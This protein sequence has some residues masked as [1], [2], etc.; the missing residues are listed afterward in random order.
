MPDDTVMQVTKR[1]T[2]PL[3]LENISGVCPGFVRAKQMLK[4]GRDVI[5]SD[6]ILVEE[7]AYPSLEKM[8][9]E[10]KSLGLK[11]G[12][13]SS[14]EHMSA[15]PPKYAYTDNKELLTWYITPVPPVT[16][17]MLLAQIKDRFPPHYTW[18]RMAFVRDALTAVR[19][20]FRLS[21]KVRRNPLA[22]VRDAF[23]TTRRAWPQRLPS[24]ERLA[25]A[26]LLADIMRKKHNAGIFH[27]NI[28]P[29]TVFFSQAVTPRF[30]NNYSGVEPTVMAQYIPP[31]IRHRDAAL[32]LGAQS[33]DTYSVA[34]AAYELVTGEPLNGPAFDLDPPV[35]FNHPVPDFLT[36]RFSGVL[37]FINPCLG[38][39]RALWD[40][41]F[42]HYDEF[43]A[44]FNE[45]NWPR[46]RR[47][48]E[49]TGSFARSIPFVRK[50]LNIWFPTR[51]AWALRIVLDYRANESIFGATGRL[52][53][54]SHVKKNADCAFLSRAF[55]KRPFSQKSRLARLIQEII[56]ENTVREP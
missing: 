50:F 7:V 48:N 21:F 51:T 53:K 4:I 44:T 25:L 34:L 8:T 19:E 36:K 37:S 27:N 42:R 40:A 46:F 41:V 47:L 9:A 13:A 29:H 2:E 23:D 49:A 6:E 32:S 10:L 35:A 3:S 16:L 56:D 15:P 54:S 31:A 26:A 30:L 52:F 39:A 17:A 14:F 5:A 45:S 1:F 55:P 11:A 38:F 43:L 28:F 12:L 24:R 33:Q 20:S 18:N 22:A